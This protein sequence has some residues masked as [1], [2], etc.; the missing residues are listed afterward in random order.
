MN[1]PRVRIEGRRDVTSETGQVVSVLASRSEA[2]YW[3]VYAV[4]PDGLADWTADFAHLQD[5]RR[6]TARW[7]R[8]VSL[9]CTDHTEELP[10]TNQPQPGRLAHG[11]APNA[12]PRGRPEPSRGADP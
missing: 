6:H 8:P 10:T 9:L 1:A 3:G 12:H 5:A 4:G 2:E 11:S 7:Q